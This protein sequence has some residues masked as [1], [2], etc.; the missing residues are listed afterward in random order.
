MENENG[1]KLAKA[2]ILRRYRATSI[3]VENEADWSVG[4]KIAIASSY[5]GRM[6]YEEVEIT[7]NFRESYSLYTCL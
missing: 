4:D 2:S 1:H 6:E 7:Q 3:E 5:S